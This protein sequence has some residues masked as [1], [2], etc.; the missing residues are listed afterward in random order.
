MA[1]SKDA[2]IDLLADIDRST[3]L[4][5]GILYPKR[6]ERPFD[7][8]HKPIFQVIDRRP[9]DPGYSP[10]KCIIAPR[11][12]GKT[13]IGAMLVPSIAVLLQRYDYII[14]IGHNA[15]DA[16][17]KTEDLKFELTTNKL[18]ETL[19]GDIRTD[20]WSKDEYV[21]KIGSKF[22]KIHPRGS[23]QPVRGRLYH[24]HRPGL[25][26]VDDLE[27]AEETETE[28]QR[29]K[30]KTWFYADVLNAIDEGKRP[31]AGQVAPW[32]ILVIGTILHHDSLLINLHESPYWDSVKLEICDDNFESN[33]PNFM[34][35]ERCREKYQQ[36]KDDN[37]IY[38]WFR[39]YRNN[40]VPTGEDAAFQPRYFRYYEESDRDL[41]RDPNIEN[42]VIIEPSRTANP[43][44]N[45]TGIV[46][47][48]IDT[49]KHCF[50]VRDCLS[51]R[52]HIEEMYDQLAERIVRYEASLLAVEITGLHEF[53]QNP[54]KQFLA[55]RGISVPWMD[56]HARG[57]G[58]NEKGKVQRVRSLVDYYRSGVMYH[59]PITC[60]PLEQQLQKYP[61]SD[62]WSLMDP[63]GYLPEILEQ[64]ER[65]LSFPGEDE[66]ERRQDVEAEYRE[67]E[68]MYAEEGWD[69][70]V[71]VDL[72]FGIPI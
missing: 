5:A 14:V 6:F 51:K 63:L 61:S 37:E 41:N 52:M 29:A 68:R 17:E 13:S 25:I 26:I 70:P 56:L 27:K 66:Y 34:S 46:V 36:F 59:N 32:E 49:Q 8:I 4:A 47:V 72:D 48:G 71:G 67:L 57:G 43:T 55:K 28:E 23:G 44:S 22:I 21:V 16:V 3:A 10:Y 24:G 15:G 31:V 19:Y 60:D 20:A 53:I 7:K 64:G 9:G 18:V 62:E 35:N 54:L 33:A 42:I 65:F 58:N 39:E 11:G 2:K 38:V 69:E 12:V 50:Y 30:K 1:L 40:P 45:P